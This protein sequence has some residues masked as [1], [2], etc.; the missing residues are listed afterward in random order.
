MTAI[1]YIE[2]SCFTKIGDGNSGTSPPPIYTVE[3]S[4]E[5]LEQVA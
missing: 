2:I 4:L 5:T 1:Y 3:A